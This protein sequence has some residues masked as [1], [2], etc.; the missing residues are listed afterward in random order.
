MIINVRDSKMVQPSEEVARQRVWIS[1]ID[2]KTPNVHTPSVYFYKTNTTSNFFDAKIMKE[3]LSK[4]LVLFYPM[5]GRLFCDKDNRVE[6]DC[7]SQG[8]LFVEADTD[9]F[10]DDFGD[11]APTLHLCKLIPIVDYSHGI[12]TYPLLVLQVCFN[13][14]SFTY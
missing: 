8:V 7:D 2:L 10:I 6:I 14:S 5:S 4:V 12:G 11:F 1:N 13:F 9:S 3:A